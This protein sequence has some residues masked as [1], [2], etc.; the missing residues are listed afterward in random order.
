MKKL[1]IS[2]SL[3]SNPIPP[4]EI[5][6]L[7]GVEPHT[8][9]LQGERNRELDLSR[10]NIWSIRSN[11]SLETVGEQWKEFVARF[12]QKWSELVEISKRGAVN[13]TI[14]VDATSHLPSVIIPP[15]MSKAAYLL[16]S[17]IDIDYYDDKG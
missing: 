10:H 9:L 13:I 16:N 6:R 5:S 1:Q 11:A 14:I 3:D 8:A 2:L 4:R 7:L 12:G 15:E 17:V